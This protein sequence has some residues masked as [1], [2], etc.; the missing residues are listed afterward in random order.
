VTSLEDLAAEFGVPVDGLRALCGLIGA[1]LDTDNRARPIELPAD[2]TTE[3][4]DDVTTA[5][6]AWWDANRPNGWAAP[7]QDKHPGFRVDIEVR[8]P[9]APG[10]WRIVRTENHNDTGTTSI[11]LAEAAA[12]SYAGAGRTP[13]WRVQVYVRTT[14]MG[15]VLRGDRGYPVAL[16][17]PETTLSPA[18]LGTMLADLVGLPPLARAQRALTLAGMLKSWLADIRWAAVYEATRTMTREQAAD[19][20]G[21]SAS[22]VGQ[23]IAAYGKSIAIDGFFDDP[24]TGVR[25]QRPPL[26]R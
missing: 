7:P 25:R 11:H 4:P 18:V 5:V 6:R 23:I 22:A 15:A 24:S 12:R 14:D 8:D 19:A 9:D 21:I 13:P 10:G 1:G 3:L 16:A 20:L 2:D 17:G 26:P